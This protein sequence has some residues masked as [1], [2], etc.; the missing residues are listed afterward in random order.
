MK[1]SLTN[2]LVTRSQQGVQPFNTYMYTD[3]GNLGESANW[4]LLVV[5]ADSSSKWES[6]IPRW[7]ACESRRK[8]SFPAK[9]DH[10]HSVLVPFLCSINICSGRGRKANRSMSSRGCDRASCLRGLYGSDRDNNCRQ[11]QGDEVYLHYTILLPDHLNNNRFQPPL[12]SAPTFWGPRGFNWH[13]SVLWGLAA[14][15]QKL[16]CWVDWRLLVG[17]H[18]PPN[19]FGAL[20]TEKQHI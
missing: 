2:R 20:I 4:S 6:K 9:M 11:G 18:A 10:Q 1:G 13:S 5:T 3:K 14:G 15:S 16:G 12:S 19:A 17:A 8:R 7:E